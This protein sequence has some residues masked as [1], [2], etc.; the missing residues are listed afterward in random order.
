MANI[1]SQKKRNR[2]NE[3][4]RLRNRAMRSELKTRSRNAVEV[5]ES[6]D[7]TAADA[8]LRDAQQRIDMAVSKGLLHKNTAARRKSRLAKQVTKTLG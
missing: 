5:A 4:A 2:Q 8:A 3:A 1:E 7:A 6:G